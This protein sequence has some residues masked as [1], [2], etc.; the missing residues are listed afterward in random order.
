MVIQAV[1]IR[2]FLVVFY[3]NELCMGLIFGV[4]LFSIA[5]G[6]WIYS[7][8]SR[9]ARGLWTLFLTMATL[10]SLLPFLQVCL[11]R[12][13]R[14]FL[15]VPSGLFIPFFS[16][17]AAAFLVIIPYGLI[18]G[19][20]F[21]LGC[22]LYARHDRDS[23]S[24]ATLFSLE[25]AGALTGGGLFSYVLVERFSSF[26]ILW[27][28]LIIIWC[29]IILSTLL[30]LKGA[31][32]IAVSAGIAVLLIGA[33]LSW[34]LLATLER[35]TVETRW[36]SL[37]E[38]L[39]LVDSCD[40]KYQHLSLTCQADQFSVYGNGQYDFS[41]PDPYGDRVTAHLVLS[42]HPHPEKVLLLGMASGG[43]ISECLKHGLESVS[44]VLLDEKVMTLVS[45]H[46]TAGEK[47]GYQNSRVRIFY[48]DGRYWITR[49]KETYD[50]IFLMLA[51]PSNS[52]LNR[53]YTEEF[54]LS[55]KHV[56][57]EK[58]VLAL[59]LTASANYLGSE[60]TDY[61]VSIY[62]TLRKVFPFVVISPGDKNYYFASPSSSVV[63]TDS[64]VLQER[65]RKSGVSEEDFSPYLFDE[66][67]YPERVKFVTD[68]F[69]NRMAPIN[70]DL[71]PITCFYNLLIWDRIS[72]SQMSS[73]LRALPSLRLPV[74]LCILLCL[75]AVRAGY[76]IKRKTPAENQE[77]LNL[78]VTVGICGFSAMGLELVLIF[79]YQ[80]LF[81][82]LYQMIGI[83]VASFMFGLAAGSF[84]GGRLLSSGR[85]LTGLLLV[86]Q[87]LLVLFSLL[88]PFALREFSL[89]ILTVLSSGLCQAAFMGIIAG[90]GF[91]NGLVFPMA[92]GLYLAMEPNPGRVAG[93]M[94]AA[95]HCGAAAGG[96]VFGTFLVPLLGIG[97]SCWLVALLCLCGMALWA[98]IPL[99]KAYNKI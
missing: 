20:V 10:L 29:A 46:L 38:G 63:T 19:S 5:L 48:T 6:A 94:N 67:F 55:L 79:S 64:A 36:G 11:I 86:I 7:L 8:Y 3:G 33:C 17:C 30:L 68:A 43:F 18:I 51:E 81:G 49:T 26:E 95:D 9:K 57:N 82:Y 74:L 39:P 73:F 1:V 16:M 34:P 2:E 76:V 28:L 15:H 58:G 13:I 83:L 12:S 35:R 65:I 45:P 22:R 59:S 97:Y 60:I 78:L 56:M 98:I 71:R 87:A 23:Q 77:K 89:H 40:S 53:F 50:V 54:F 99:S 21:P 61:N 70:S 75:V 66:L 84:F 90:L 69:R 93:L 32:R 88:I 72:G 44:Y 91:F 62:N 14:V 42:E 37:V 31:L 41:F 92:G 80:N 85:R 24:I 96:F 4:W 52:M 47:N 25:S 27:G